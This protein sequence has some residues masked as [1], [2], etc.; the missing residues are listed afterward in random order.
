MLANKP[1]GGRR[2][3]ESLGTGLFSPGF[4]LKIHTKTP[5]TTADKSRQWH[6]GRRTSDRFALGRQLTHGNGHR[7][8]AS[9]TC[10]VGSFLPC[11]EDR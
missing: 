8:E 2:D 4:M 1:E 10:L 5:F 9:L 3:C 7:L 6:E 11:S